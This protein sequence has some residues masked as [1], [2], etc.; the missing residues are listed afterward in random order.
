MRPPCYN[1]PPRAEG[2]WM[3]VRYQ[4]SRPDQRRMEL[5]FAP[6]G[7][8]RPVYRWVPAFA[9]DKCTAHDARGIGPNGET[10]PDAHGWDCRGCRWRPFG[11]VHPRPEEPLH[12]RSPDGA[13]ALAYA[14]AKPVDNPGHNHRVI[15][16]GAR[17][18]GKTTRL[19]SLL[20]ELDEEPVAIIALGPEQLERLRA[21]PQWELARETL[22]DLRKEFHRRAIDHYARTGQPVRL[23]CGGQTIGYVG[24]HLMPEPALSTVTYEYEIPNPRETE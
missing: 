11:L 10:Y 24:G 9:E 6:V 14:F 3:L 19:R 4:P 23:E 8:G 2:Q 7:L 1:R 15:H 13:D 22:P 16:H 5:G 20:R 12:E 21:D 18:G 17:G